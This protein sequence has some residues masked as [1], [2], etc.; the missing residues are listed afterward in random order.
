MITRETTP[1]PAWQLSSLAAQSRDD[2]P[3]ESGLV[4]VKLNSCPVK[5]GSLPRVKESSLGLLLVLLG[6]G[7]LLAHFS[8]ST[9]IVGGPAGWEGRRGDVSKALKPASKDARG[10]EGNSGKKRRRNINGGTNPNPKPTKANSQSSTATKAT[11]AKYN[12]SPCILQHNDI[13]I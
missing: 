4:L 8:V 11:F 13:L 12:I 7:S 10:E 6:F 1:P 3:R 5:T 2:A 9:I